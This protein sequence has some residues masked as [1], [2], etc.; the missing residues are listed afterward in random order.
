MRRAVGAGAIVLGIVLPLIPLLLQAFARIW[1][2]P[3]LLPADWTLR[4]FRVA[5]DPGSEIVRGLLT[6]LGIGIAVSV[7]SSAVGLAAGRA[8]GHYRFPGRRLAQFLLLA[9]AIV[10]GLA[11]TLG[12]QIYF[13]RFG[14]ADTVAGVVLVHL[15]PTIPSGT[16]V[17]TGAFSNLEVDYEAQARSLGAG[18]VRTFWHVTLPI[19][20]PSLAVAAFFAFLISWSEYILTLV[21]GGGSVQTLP[22]LLFAYLGSSDLTLAA[23]LA[24]V[25]VIP[26]VL[27]VTLTSRY[28]TGTSPAA[29]GFGRL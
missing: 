10:P 15:I 14:L 23:A 29:V 26:P 2:Y 9:P 3:S 25:F 12:I 8:L 6:S 24:V 7:I 28:L 13:L 4:G 27:L 21:I 18:P 19:V 22:L 20:R 1:R 11:V 16:L 17:L 5:T